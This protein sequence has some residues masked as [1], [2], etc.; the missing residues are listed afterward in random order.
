MMNSLP[1]Y[2]NEQNANWLRSQ[3]KFTAVN[4]PGRVEANNVMNIRAQEEQEKL[5][6]KKNKPAKPLLFD[7][8]K[9]L[10]KTD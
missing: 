3:S 5:Y 8:Y 2:T 4:N 9:T 7:Y 6:S 1:A 10:Y